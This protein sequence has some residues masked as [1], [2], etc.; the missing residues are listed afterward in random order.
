MQAQKTKSVITL[1]TTKF[2]HL[3]KL[4]VCLT[5]RF[6]KCAVMDRAALTDSAPINTGHTILQMKKLLNLLILPPLQILKTQRT[7]V[8]NVT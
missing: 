4:G 8:T 7:K 2:A 5:I 3:K 6:L 1:I